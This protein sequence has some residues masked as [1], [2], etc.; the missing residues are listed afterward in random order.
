MAYTQKVPDW[1]EAGTEP[2]ETQKQTGFQPGMKP[3]AQWFNWFLNWTYLA[4]KE[5]QEKAAEQSNVDFAL[6]EVQ[7]DIIQLQADIGNAD[8]PPASLTVAGKVQLSNKI[9]GD[10]ESLAPTEK[11]LGVV[12]AEAT[13]AKQLGVEQKAN[14]VAALNSIGITAS[15]SE[16][17]DSLISKMAGVIRS[18]G[19]ATAADLLSGKTASNVNGPLTGTM[20]NR[21]GHVTGQSVTNSGTTLRIRPQQGYYP[22]DSANSVQITNANFLAENIALGVN[23]FGLLGTLAINHLAYGSVSS[24]TSGGLISLTVPGLTFDPK[25][26][27]LIMDQ[28]NLVIAVIETPYG[29]PTHFHTTLNNGVVKNGWNSRNFTKMFQV[30]YAASNNQLAPGLY[31]YVLIG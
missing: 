19:N 31:K 9:D 15:T 29:L 21:T 13:A 8:I 28:Y 10:S 23:L 20:P 3:P 2:S 25:L 12:M 30:T 11:A 5:L 16:S 27:L 14:V 4:L 1:H 6:E 24:V 7:A 22:G 18:T 17:W 26:A